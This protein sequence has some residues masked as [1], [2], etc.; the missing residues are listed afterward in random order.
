MAHRSNQCLLAS[1]P[2]Y[3]RRRDAHQHKVDP[4]PSHS[5]GLQS[6]LALQ[7]NIH[8]LRNPLVF[9]GLRMHLLSNR[10]SSIQ[11]RAFRPNLPKPTTQR[12][13]VQP[14][15]EAFYSSLVFLE[16]APQPLVETVVVEEVLK[17]SHLQINLRRLLNNLKHSLNVAVRS[18]ISL[19]VAEVGWPWQGRSAA[20]TNYR[21][22]PRAASRQSW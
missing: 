6:P 18:R 20:G 14:H 2:P 21:L 11:A 19:E 13:Q 16:E 15:F 3:N 4:K 8:S 9:L 1:P 10:D 22:A 17:H 7:C 5:K 12:V